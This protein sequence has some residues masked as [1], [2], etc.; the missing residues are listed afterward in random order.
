MALSEERQ[1]A[2]NTLR[3][4]LEQEKPELEK[5]TLASLEKMGIGQSS[6]GGEL[7][8]KNLSNLT[9]KLTQYG[10]QLAEQE[11]RAKEATSIRKE[12]MVFTRE[13]D[14]ANRRWQE[15]MEN[16]RIATLKSMEPSGRTKR[17][18]ALQGGL[19]SLLAGA[20]TGGIGAGL[21]LLGMGT[22]VLGGAGLGAVSGAGGVSSM[23]GQNFGMK[24]LLE[25]LR[26]KNDDKNTESGTIYFGGEVPSTPL[27]KEVSDDWMDW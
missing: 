12:N 26:G 20:A 17:R 15:S 19:Q 18:Q 9:G 4:L 21:G 24:Q 23:I 13:R 16:W 27:S 14:E 1:S 6:V 2:Y 5:S 22:S 8:R 3:Q 25:L 11:A 7:M 10:G